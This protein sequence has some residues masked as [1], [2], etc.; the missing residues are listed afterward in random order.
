MIVSFDSGNEGWS[1][2]VLGKSLNRPGAELISGDITIGDMISKSTKYN[3]GQYIRLVLSFYDELSADKAK[4]IYDEFIDLLMVG[5]RED[6]Y[7]A[8]GVMHTDTSH[9]HV[10]GRIPKL[11]LFAGTQLKIYNHRSDVHRI[12]AIKAFLV[13]K[14]G[15]TPTLKKIVKGPEQKKNVI[16]QMRA[17]AGQEPFIFTKKKDR[18]RQILR[19]QDIVL[20]LISAGHIDSLDRVKLMLKNQGLKVV[21]E[22][23]DRKLAQHYLTVENSSGKIRLMGLI[24][25]EKFYSSSKAVQK[26]AISEKRDVL[27]EESLDQIQSKLGAIQA[28]RILFIEKQYEKSRFRAEEREKEVLAAAREEAISK[29]IK[30]KIDEQQTTVQQEIKVS[31][32]NRGARERKERRAANRRRSVASLVTGTKQRVRKL[33]DSS[34]GITDITDDTYQAIAE[35]RGRNKSN[36]HSK[37]S[38]IAVLSAVSEEYGA[39]IQRAIRRAFEEVKKTLVTEEVQKEEVT[40]EYVQP[41]IVTVLDDDTDVPGQTYS[42]LNL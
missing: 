12:E 39:I 14:H 42:G 9:N 4:E 38:F 13:K 40:A 10:H 6:E 41:E 23:Y 36:R 29:P 31:E 37:R 3:S 7:H 17:E 15:L 22:G 18:D 24:F 11:N 30:R 26:R 34:T 33:D 32:T 1:K 21:K 28:K 20:G 25:G 19:L 5:Y 2:Y 16:Q 35:R 27:E 8:D